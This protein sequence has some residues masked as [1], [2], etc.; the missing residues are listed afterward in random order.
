MLNHSIKE[1]LKNVL[2]LLIVGLSLF[3]LLKYFDYRLVLISGQIERAEMDKTILQDKYNNMEK[4]VEALD[5]LISL[6]RE[7][8]E[9]YS[10]IY[11]LNENYVPSSL[12]SIPRVYV[13]RNATHFQM[14]TSVLPY[15]KRLMDAGNNAGI[16]L[17]A[18]SAYRSFGEQATL[19]KN[20]IIVY[21]ATEANKFSADQGYSEHQ[22]GTT[23]DFTT[24]KLN[25][26][27]E[28]FDKTPEYK[29]LLDNAYQ[30][31]FVLSYPEGNTYY[32]FEPWHWR[33][34]GVALATRLHVENKDFYNMDQRE[35]DKY[36]INIFD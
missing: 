19:K 36:L 9:K 24:A 6:D 34:V 31:G 28:G 21:G 23:L 12:T 7:L 33:F 20:Y 5:K 32:K 3:G 26:E 35:I 22:L 10:K 2:V 15:L 17:Q 16:T 8:L 30:Y 29:W 27:L 11:F 14:H 18:L 4:K 1:L 25:G 13:N